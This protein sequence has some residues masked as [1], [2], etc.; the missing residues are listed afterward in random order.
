MKSG[1]H[2]D[3]EKQMYSIFFWN[4]RSFPLG[5]ISFCLFSFRKKT[6]SLMQFPRK[7]HN[8]NLK[9]VILKRQLYQITGERMRGYK[10]N[11]VTRV[12][13]T[14][15]SRRLT[16]LLLPS[17][18]IF[19]PTVTSIFISVS[20]FFSSTRGLF[21]FNVETIF[22][23]IPFYNRRYDAQYIRKIYPL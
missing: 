23:S 19:H 5:N 7:E 9:P 8:W 11:Q 16:K 4:R 17:R 10:K 14:R 6:R 18:P 22:H 3:R 13:K 1:L 21:N 2:C 20:P 12:M 15:P